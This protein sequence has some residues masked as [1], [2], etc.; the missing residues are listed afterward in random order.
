MCNAKCIIF[1]SVRKSL[2]ASLA[3]LNL[4]SLW[5]CLVLVTGA[6]VERIFNFGNLIFCILEL[7]NEFG[8]VAQFS[9]FNRIIS[10]A[11]WLLCKLR[12]IEK[13]VLPDEFW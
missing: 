11:F 13:K 4:Q 9:S 8:K 12:G 6:G 10:V 5:L 1:T 3:I 7:A 2:G